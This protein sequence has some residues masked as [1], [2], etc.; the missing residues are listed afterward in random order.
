MLRRVDVGD[1][2]AAGAAESSKA[3]PAG[4][5]LCGLVA[6]VST[7]TLQLL[8]G[9][10][11]ALSALILTG[12]TT[13][14]AVARAVKLRTVLTIV[15][16]FG[17]GKAIGQEGVARVLADI[18]VFVLAPFCPHGLLA[19]VFAATV[20]LGVIFHGTAVVV[21]MFPVCKSIAEGMGMPI[22]QLVSVLCI[23]VSCQMLSPISYQTNLVAYSTGGYQFADFSK[24]GAGLVICL[25][26]VAIPLCERAFPAP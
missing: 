10:F 18:L 21:L 24:V 8:E 19:A 25:A 11:L 1:G 15:G 16:A 9:V 26:F 7:E 23:S 2:A 4:L 5:I 14:D 20:A 22:H 13:M 17:L 12:C 3:V 6:L